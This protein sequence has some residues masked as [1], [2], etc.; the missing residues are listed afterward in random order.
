MV[1][2]KQSRIKK[3]SKRKSNIYFDK[4]ISL[5]LNDDI[6]NLISYWIRH[7]Q[8][9]DEQGKPLF[10]NRSHFV[11]CALIKFFNELKVKYTI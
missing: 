10:N 6:L 7:P 9:I 3:T 8:T 11:K 1:S 4:F 2:T 5:R